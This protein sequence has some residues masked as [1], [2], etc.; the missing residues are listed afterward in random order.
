MPRATAEA[1][2]SA[3]PAPSV[4]IITA[5]QTKS[6]DSFWVWASTSGSPM[7]A[8]VDQKASLTH[9]R[10]LVSDQLF[11]HVHAVNGGIA[12]RKSLRFITVDGDLEKPWRQRAL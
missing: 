4:A 10:S 12:C 5:P 2:L 7:S 9:Q 11:K 8:S 3:R 1:L 6:K